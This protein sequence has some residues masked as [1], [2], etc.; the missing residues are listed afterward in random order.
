MHKRT[1]FFS[2]PQSQSKEKFPLRSKGEIIQPQKKINMFRRIKPRCQ[3]EL[4]TGL[5]VEI[6]SIHIGEYYLMGQDFG[7]GIV[8]VPLILAA[9]AAYGIYVN[10]IVGV[11]IRKKTI[12]LPLVTGAGALVAILA[13]A[14]LVPR[15]S[16][17]GAACA[18]LMAY[19][20]MAAG[21][22]VLNRRIYPV[23]YEG[24]RLFH[25]LILT[26]GLFWAG[27]YWPMTLPR[28]L[29]YRWAAFA[30]PQGKHCAAGDLGVLYS[31]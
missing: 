21:L 12:W 16:I 7:E 6:I 26:A 25:I 18:T 22:Y 9:Y 27:W 23:P 15:F 31:A 4:W 1:S 14:L 17:Q 24:L 19:L 10:L 5:P 11:Y 20:S 30:L 13:N 8:I 28:V 2:N 3:T 29:A